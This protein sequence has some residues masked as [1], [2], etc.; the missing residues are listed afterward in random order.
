MSITDFTG[1]LHIKVEEARN[2]IPVRTSGEFC[3][4]AIVRLRPFDSACKQTE[5]TSGNSEPSIN[6]HVFKDDT[7]IFK[8]MN[9]QTLEQSCIEIG[10]W[11]REEHTGDTLLGIVRFNNGSKLCNQKESL[12]MD[13]SSKES[14]MWNQVI[15]MPGTWIKSKIPLR[16]PCHL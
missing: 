14:N 12:W 16:T 1:E 4:Y 9:N 13:S 15:N 10:I 2:L 11:D 6:R 8:S 3:A 7:F 5:S